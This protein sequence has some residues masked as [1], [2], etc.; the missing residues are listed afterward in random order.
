MSRTRNIGLAVLGVLSVLDLLTP[1]LAA[2]GDGPPMSVGIAAALLG[3]TSLACLVAVLTSGSPRAALL[4][5][6]GTRL[7]SAFL[8]V[9]GLFV[10]GV[11]GVVRIIAGGVIAATAIG[12][13]LA[14]SRGT[15]VVAA[16]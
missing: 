2:G 14:L 11:P 13:S 15:R 3:A 4:G 5:L 9:P 16:R 7:V 12:V 6:V 1:V 8:A 10:E